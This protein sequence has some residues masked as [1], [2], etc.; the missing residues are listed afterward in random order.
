LETTLQEFEPGTYKLIVLDAMY[1]FAI[2]GVSENDNA[3]MAE[4]YNLLD[5][6]AAHTKAAIVVVHHSAKGYQNAKRVTDVGA[7]A[8][9]QS[10]AADSHLVLREHKLN[11]V[12]VLEAA[13]RSFPT[14][15]PMALMFE[16]PAWVPLLDVDPTQLKTPQIE[17]QVRRDE[18]AI[19]KITEALAGEPATPRKL[20]DATGMGRDR[21]QR[22]L[23]LMESQ[24]LVERNPTEVKGNSTYEYRLTAEGMRDDRTVA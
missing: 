11:G 23:T 19:S 16:Y 17:R 3:A 20:R 21:I 8:G 14:V 6:I 10:R 12:F 22:L 13:V 7:G 9:A 18:E 2:D 1:R 15:E 5:R 4:F 24:D